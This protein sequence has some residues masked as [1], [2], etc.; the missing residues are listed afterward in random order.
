[1]GKLN[2]EGHASP[3]QPPSLSFLEAQSRAGYLE[4]ERLTCCQPESCDLRWQLPLDD[5]FVS[6]KTGGLITKGE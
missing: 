3:E 4:K 1:M 6:A 5:M 2:T